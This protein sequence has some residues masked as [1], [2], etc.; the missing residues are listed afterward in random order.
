MKHYLNSFI[1]HC[2]INGTNSVICLAV[3]IFSAFYFD[4][5]VLRSNV[6]SLRSFTSTWISTSDCRHFNNYCYTYSNKISSLVITFSSTA[7]DAC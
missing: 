6:I 5:F 2:R 3:L 4:F 7:T 1:T